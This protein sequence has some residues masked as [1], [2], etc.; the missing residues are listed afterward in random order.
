MTRVVSHYGLVASHGE[1]HVHSSLSLKLIQYF[2]GVAKRLL[3]AGG[4][5][6]NGKRV[7]QMEKCLEREDFVDGR[8]AVLRSGKEEHLIL[9]LV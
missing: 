4:L 7:V 6:L 2:L 3:Q 9:E 8:V 1:F 5:Y